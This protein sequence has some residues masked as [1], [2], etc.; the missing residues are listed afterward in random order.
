MPLARPVDHPALYVRKTANESVTSS[1]VLQNDDHLL[2]QVAANA[3]YL[4]ELFLIYDGDAAGD[5]QIGFTFPAGATIDW[6]PGGLTTGATQ[7]SGSVKLAHVSTGAGEGVGAV[8]TGAGNRVV[9]RATGILQVAGTA[10]TLQLQWAQLA[11][12]ATATTVLANSWMALRR[13]S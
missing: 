6:T 11:S 4:L 1:A 10:G 3:T 9:A 2:L 8:G 12:S 7:Q 13:I 5:I